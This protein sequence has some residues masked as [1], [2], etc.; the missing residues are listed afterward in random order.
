MEVAKAAEQSYQKAGRKPWRKVGRAISSCSPALLPFTRVIPQDGYLTVL[1][2]GLKLV[3]G[4]CLVST[5]RNPLAKAEIRHFQALTSGEA[6]HSK[7]FFE[8][9]K[10][11][12]SRKL[13]LKISWLMQH[14]P[15]EP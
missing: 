8:Y 1:A 11:S 10:R 12:S 5:K 7:L 6:V 9:Q 13:S 14:Y 4:V 2:G 3:F 15:S